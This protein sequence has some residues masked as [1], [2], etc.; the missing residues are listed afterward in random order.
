MVCSPSNLPS[1]LHEASY[2]YSTNPAASKNPNT[3]TACSACS[4]PTQT[5]SSSLTRSAIHSWAT[6]T[7][8]LTGP[9]SLSACVGFGSKL[10]QPSSSSTTPVRNPHS[11][12]PAQARWSAALPP[13]ATPPTPSSFSNL[14]GIPSRSNTISPAAPNAPPPLLS[15]SHTISLPILLPLPSAANL[16]SLTLNHSMPSIGLP[17][18]SP[19]PMPPSIPPNSTASP[20]LPILPPKPSASPAITPSPPA[21]SSAIPPKASMA[22]STTS[23]K[24]ASL[25]PLPI[26]R[27]ALGLPWA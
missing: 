5:H 6:K 3:L 25:L 26:H 16:P 2:R 19:K 24:C 7:Q 20:N 9:T 13:S 14:A 1:Q 17:L 18:P 21:P 15:P 8:P 27:F 10:V 12:P 11:I 23:P 4:T 22:T